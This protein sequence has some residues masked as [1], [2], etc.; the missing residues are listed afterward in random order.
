LTVRYAKFFVALA[1]AAVTAA[2][3][4][5]LTGRPAQ[6]LTVVAAVVAAGAVYAVPNTPTPPAGVSGTYTPTPR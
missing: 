3:Q 6:V 2:L 5:G 4:L 1:G